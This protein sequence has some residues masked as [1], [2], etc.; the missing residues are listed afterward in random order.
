MVMAEMDTS[1]IY[2]MRAGPGSRQLFVPP[3]K[4]DEKHKID[5][6]VG[7]DHDGRNEK[8]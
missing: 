7:R 4:G 3:T 2:K 6:S 1:S 8:P 5:D